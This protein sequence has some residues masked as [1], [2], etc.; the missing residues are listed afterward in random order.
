M[1]ADARAKTRFTTG[2]IINKE[3]GRQTGGI[4]RVS[5]R[6]DVDIEQVLLA[7]CRPALVAARNRLPRGPVPQSTSSG[8]AARSPQVVLVLDP[9][10]TPTC[11][12]P[13]AYPSVY[14][15]RTLVYI[16]RNKYFHHGIGEQDLSGFNVEVEF[17]LNGRGNRRRV[18]QNASSGKATDP[19]HLQGM[20]S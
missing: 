10:P 13:L 4:H 17:T 12:T 6:H 8:A 18:A 11:D 7:A 5:E 15:P 14:A 16:T 19:Q 9:P 2:F 3:R 20:T 1:I